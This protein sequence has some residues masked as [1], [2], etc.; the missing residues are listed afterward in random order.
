[1]PLLICIQ[2]EIKWWCC[3]HRIR[4]VQVTYPLHCWFLSV[5]MHKHLCALGLLAT[6]Q[7]F[8]S[9]QIYIYTYFRG[10]FYIRKPSEWCKEIKTNYLFRK[11]QRHTDASRKQTHNLTAKTMAI[12][13]TRYSFQALSTL[14][15]TNIHEQ[16]I[17]SIY[18]A[19]YI[20]VT[21]QRFYTETDEMVYV[22]GIFRFETKRSDTWIISISIHMH[23]SW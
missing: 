15:C 13:H 6:K 5:Q 4:K 22:H 1:M 14:T 12:T 8:T 21:A 3:C 10:K 7:H 9:V 2:D 18:D 23:V 17:C 16:C 11:I 20:H 19:I